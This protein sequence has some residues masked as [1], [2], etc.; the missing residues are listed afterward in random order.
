MQDNIY[1]HYIAIDW[2][3]INM[4]IARMTKK[5][6]KITVIDVP[7][8][9]EDLKA[10]LKNL[11][12]TKI[13]TMRKFNTSNRLKI[14]RFSTHDFSFQPNFRSNFFCKIFFHFFSF[15]RSLT[16]DCYLVCF[17]SQTLT[18]SRIAQTFFDIHIEKICNGLEYFGIFCL[19]A[20]RG[21]KNFVQTVLC[22]LSQ[23]L[24]APARR[25]AQD[26]HENLQGYGVSSPALYFSKSS[27]LPCF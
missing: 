20:C 5:S 24:P 12:G 22:C 14:L 23:R 26:R 7:S 25:H 11:R 21:F 27:N 6:N 9:I 19:N 8:D 18:V 2:S 4:A 3:I 10:Y 1:D 17:I 16:A 15:I 13:L